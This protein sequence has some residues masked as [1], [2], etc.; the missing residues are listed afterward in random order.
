[1]KALKLIF[2]AVGIGLIGFS[3]F[4]QRPSGEASDKLRNARVGKITGT[5]IDGS[6]K[7]PLSYA[8]VVLKRLKDS[9]TVTGAIADKNGKFEINDAPFGKFFLSVKFIG[10]ERK[11]I[12]DVN[13]TPQKRSIDLGEMKLRAASTQTGEVTVTGEKDFIEFKADRKVVNVA[14][15]ITSASGSAAE[16]LQNAPSVNV[17]IEGNVTLRGSSNFTVYVNGKPSVLDGSDA[18]Q[19]MP[20]SAIQK[21]EII[22]NPSAK[23]DPDGMA[24]IINVVLKKEE[25]LGLSGVF[26]ASIG[27]ND[28]YS[29]NFLINWQPD[30]FKMFIGAYY[31]DYHFEGDGRYERQTFFEDTTSHMNRTGDRNFNRG[32]WNVKGGIGYDFTDKFTMSLEGNYGNQGF[33][34]DGDMLLKTFTD[35]GVDDVTY[36]KNYSG[37]SRDED[38]YKIV[39]DANYDFNDAGH[40]LYSTIY[41]SNEKGGGTDEQRQRLTDSDW[42]VI[43]DNPYEV[44]SE[45]IEDEDNLRAKVDYTLPMDEDTKFEAG[46]QFRLNDDPEEYVFEEFLPDS[47]GWVEN[48]I[49]SSDMDFR[50]NIYSTYATFAS[51]LFGVDYKLGLRGEYTD[52]K[53]SFMDTSKIFRIDRIDFFPSVHLSKK[54]GGGHQVMASYSRRINRP[55]G[56][57]LEP[58][59]SYIDD[60]NYRQGNPELEPEYTDSYE[61][62][63]QKMFNGSF[64]SL[65]GYYRKTFNEMERLHRMTNDSVMVHMLANL[66]SAEFLGA[67]L[68]INYRPSKWLNL[69]VSGNY[70]KYSIAGDI[71]EQTAQTSANTWNLRMHGSVNIFKN[72]RLQ[73]NGFYRGPS[74]TSQGERE[75]MGG[76]DFA[77]RQDFLDKN[78]SLTLQ[79]RN[80]LGTMKRESTSYGQNFE[81]YHR[82]RREAQIVE[83]TFS[84]RFNNYKE[85]K[86]GR[87]GVGEM[88]GEMDAGF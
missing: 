86:Q 66:S 22:T 47:N 63:Y 41:F 27:T 23:F 8:S 45:E 36:Y 13:I 82:F 81:L 32:G 80:V 29:G 44:R 3:L 77:I 48:D 50:R 20:A 40:K 78:A 12:E 7:E 56:R 6:S 38:Y 64:I 34:G 88:D 61:L 74:I 43:D 17:D 30:D 11:I 72:T 68:M 28:K 55:H 31:R 42:N 52:R 71:V 37:W 58:F 85:K 59:L 53:M 4:A 69:N 67:E 76:L 5:A 15:D 87:D 16:A 24:G 10:Y 1:M 9:S 35:P 57:H 70:Y 21:I 18:L 83:L 73:I 65:E 49:F 33:S 26:D 75:G 60:Y 84:Y 39:M 54:L 62:G 19:Q 79:T 51:K 14:Q 46:L 2:T 25:D